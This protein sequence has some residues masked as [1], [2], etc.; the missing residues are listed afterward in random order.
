[1]SVAASWGY[2]SLFGGLGWQHGE[3]RSATKRTEAQHG[4]GQLFKKSSVLRPA[5]HSRRSGSKTSTNLSDPIRASR[6]IFNLADRF[7][8]VSRCPPGPTQDFFDDQLRSA[9]CMSA[10]RGVDPYNSGKG[11]SDHAGAAGQGAL[12]AK[13][14]SPFE[15]QL[16]LP[17]L[18]F[19]C[20]VQ[21]KE[22]SR[23]HGQQRP[24]CSPSGYEI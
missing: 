22:V 6:S 10:N 14:E 20:T 5:I 4:S 21:S 8:T 16:P 23:S 2:S 18:I 19:R 9:L 24:G 3:R 11:T 7:P 15:L 1:M 12:Y 17:R 13:P